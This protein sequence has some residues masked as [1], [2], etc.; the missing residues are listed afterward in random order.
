AINSD[1]W[2]ANGNMSWA[3][4][5]VLA[6]MLHEPHG[7]TPLYEELDA[8]VAYWLK[9]R[10]GSDLRNA[11]LA[12]LDGFLQNASLPLLTSTI[13]E[14]L[15]VSVSST[16]IRVVVEDGAT[17]NGYPQFQFKKGEKILCQIR[18]VHLDAEIYGPDYAVFKAERFLDD[19]IIAEGGSR[20]PLLAFG[21]GIS[22]LESNKSMFAATAAASAVALGYH[23]YAKK[24]SNDRRPPV[25]P[26]VIPW[27]GSAITLG[28]DPDAFFQKARET[29]GD[30]FTVQAAGHCWTYVTSASAIS[31]VYCNS[32]SFVAQPARL[33]F[34]HKV[35]DMPRS[36][37]YDN[38]YMAQALYPMHHRILA[39]SNIEPMVESLVKHF[40]R[41]IQELNAKIPHKTWSTTLEEF[42]HKPTFLAMAAAMFG[43][44]FKAEEASPSYE[45]FL[46]FDDY[47]PLFASGAPSFLIQRGT[48]ARNEL[49]NIFEEYF[50]TPGWDDEASELIRSV[51][52]GA[53]NESQPPWTDRE[54]A[55]AINSDFWAANGNMSWA[56]FWVLA[57][58][59]HEPHGLT[60]L[61]EELEAAVA[62]WSKARPR[63]NLLDASL[64]ELHEFLQNASLPLLTSTISETLRVSLSSSSLRVVVEDGATISGYP[65]FQF[66]KGDKILCQIRSVHFDAELYGPDA[67]AFKADRFLDSGTM[68]E[69][70]SRKPLLVWGGGASKCDGRHYAAKGCKFT[71]ALLLLHF[72]IKLDPTYRHPT[73]ATVLLDKTRIGVGVMHPTKPTNVLVSK[74]Y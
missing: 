74:R 63:S 66:K 16:S 13:S 56:F 48:R 41:R 39:S 27:L 35:F 11:S 67:A 10:P 21:G 22:K 71:L 37:V 34:S 68:A 30:I 6:L 43:P 23:H 40:V 73:S 53:R 3:F 17:I 29:Y 70:G 38:E 20:K 42:V 54:L 4:F 44:L 25:V 9:S 64:T 26:F 32:K 55:S 72:N 47:I 8:A 14:T 1:F 65:Q 15:R 24:R 61:Y 58:V 18:S 28:R 57:L 62:S 60:P 46:I 12:E 50:N 36:I 31:A 19:G 45:P 7:L 5:W 59:L 51:A 33:E 2:A 49:I 69:G 52:Y